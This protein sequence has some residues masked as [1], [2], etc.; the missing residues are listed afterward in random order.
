MGKPRLLALASGGGHW[1]Q[2]QRLKPAFEGFETAYVS[3]FESYAEQVP[4]SRYYIVPDAS[5]FDV[6][7]F[8]PVFAKALRILLKETASG[9]K[10]LVLRIA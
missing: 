2:L 6:R 4:D 5:R 3:M 1:V 7:S 8:A 9:T 10:F